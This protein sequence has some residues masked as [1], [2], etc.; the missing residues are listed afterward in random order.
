[1]YDLLK[2]LLY[3]VYF[4][5]IPQSCILSVV[6]GCN[7]LIRQYNKCPSIY[8]KVGHLYGDPVPLTL[9]YVPDRFLLTSFSN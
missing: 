8:S 3:K 5:G 4:R 7:F 6:Q 1:M 2:E 9:R